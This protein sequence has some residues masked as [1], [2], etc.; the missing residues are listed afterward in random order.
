MFI[1]TAEGLHWLEWRIVLYLGQYR[2]MQH[3]LIHKDPHIGQVFSVI[4]KFWTLEF[5]FQL[6]KVLKK[7][8]QTGKKIMLRPSEN[9]W[10]QWH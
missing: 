9:S 8:R 2:R 5:K 4:W 3:L 6:I 7:Q 1:Q 10:K